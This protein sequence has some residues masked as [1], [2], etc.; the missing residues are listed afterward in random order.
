MR[1]AIVA[2]LLLLAAGA[3][4]QSSDDEPASPGPVVAPLPPPQ[5]GPRYVLEGIEVR[6]NRKTDTAV[7]VR[8]LGLA[9][10]DVVGGTDPRVEAARLRLLSLSYFLDV[11]FRLE[12]GRR[13]PGVILVV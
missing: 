10:G 2:L 5:F 1:A 13:P 12:K 11:Q 6:G 9:V 4:A 8:E 7:I 3:R